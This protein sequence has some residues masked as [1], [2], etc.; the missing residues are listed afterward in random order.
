MAARPSAIAALSTDFQVGI[1]QLFHGR[2]HAAVF[3]GVVVDRPGHAD[4]RGARNEYQ[5]DHRDCKGQFH[6]TPLWDVAA[7][8]RASRVEIARGRKGLRQIRVNEV[9]PLRYWSIGH[10]LFALNLNLIAPR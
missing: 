5:C 7:K 3:G 10:L 9:F 8:K 1:E 2:V 4:S 6:G